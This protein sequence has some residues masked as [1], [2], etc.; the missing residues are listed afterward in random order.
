MKKI[1]YLRE[2]LAG[3]CASGPGK[4]IL[5]LILIA[6]LP[7]IFVIGLPALL[8]SAIHSQWRGKHPPVKIDGVHVAFQAMFYIVLFIVLICTGLT[9]IE[10]AINGEICGRESRLTR[11]SC[12][13]FSNAFWKAS[14]HFFLNYLFFWFS[15]A[16]ICIGLH[17]LLAAEKPRDTDEQGR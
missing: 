10:F 4:S 5:V 12:Y 16:F 7:L 13:D 15:L 3:F 2:K 9:L 8:L 11:V 14:L 1:K 6:M 17:G